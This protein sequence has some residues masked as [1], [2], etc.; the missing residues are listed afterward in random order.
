[1]NPLFPNLLLLSLVDNKFKLPSHTAKLLSNT[2][3]LLSNTAKLLSNTIKLLSNTVMF[4]FNTANSHTVNSDL[5]LAL[6]PP[7]KTLLE[8]PKM[9]KTNNDLF[10]KIYIIFTEFRKKFI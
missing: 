5:K 3:K 4:P 8:L 2:A 1:M 6:N 9:K 7:L 10:F